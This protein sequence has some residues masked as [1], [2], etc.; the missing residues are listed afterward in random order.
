MNN[1][2]KPDLDSLIVMIGDPADTCIERCNR[3]ITEDM[4]H[5]FREVVRHYYLYKSLLKVKRLD[6]LDTPG[7]RAKDYR[8]IKFEDFYR[9]LDRSTKDIIR[10]KNPVEVYSVFQH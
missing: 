8:A 4:M 3:M 2:A 7:F 5:P 9:K 6:A 1:N 10:I